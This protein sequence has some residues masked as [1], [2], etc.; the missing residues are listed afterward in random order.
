MFATRLGFAAGILAS[1]AVGVVHDSPTAHRA[2]PRAHVARY[3]AAPRP[4]AVRPL[5]SRLIMAMT[6]R[7]HVCEEGGYGWHV[8]GPTYFGGLGWLWV[9]WQTYRRAD[10][11]RSMAD[12]T[13]AQQA[14]AMAH[15]ARVYG[16]PDQDGCWAGG[17]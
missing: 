10:F 4:V 16:W 5:V 7:V 6:E 15:F 17:Y 3:R 11:P 14:W 9:T 13:P 12:A 8:N 2:P 1:A